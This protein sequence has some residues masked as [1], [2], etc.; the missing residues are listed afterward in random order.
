M[1][2]DTADVSHISAQVILAVHLF[3]RAHRSDGRQLVHSTASSSSV[4]DKA[5]AGGILDAASR[6]EAQTLDSEVAVS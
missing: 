2:P 3:K 5:Q 1:H 4:T 6:L